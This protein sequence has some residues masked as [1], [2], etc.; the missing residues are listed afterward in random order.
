[1]SFRP[2]EKAVLMDRL[3][4]QTQVPASES[5]ST[6]PPYIDSFLA[7][8]RLLIGVPFHYLVPDARLLPVESIRFFYLDR[9]WTDRLVDGAA[10]VGKIGTR[11]LC[12][13]QAQ[14][15]GVQRL[16]DDTES[17]VR[18]LQRRVV[19]DF[20]AT[21]NDPERPRVA[22]DTVTGFLLRSALVSGWPHMEV[23]A[24]RDGQRLTILRLERLSP[25]VMIA[26]FR[27]VPDRVEL[28]EPHHGVQFG[29]DGS[30][31]NYRVFLRS[32]TGEQV[33][34]PSNPETRNVPL[35][36]GGKN[37]LHVAA[38]RQRL[39]AARSSQPAAIA[40]TGSAA[41]AIAVLNP[42]YRQPFQGSGGAPSGPKVPVAERVL[43]EALFTALR[44]AIGGSNG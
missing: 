30:A 21:K 43:D 10:A 9:S 33:P 17:L 44:L 11:E 3:K 38:L 12:H 23:K 36:V 18:G 34:S 35:R 6:L 1:M 5:L 19:K 32:A 20:V 4:A 8:L 7:H 39:H 2:S 42:P 22:A 14:L 28:E 40:Q 29:V 31:P 15:P 16:V 13:A 27:G 25:G 24:F 37:V 26:L 41:F